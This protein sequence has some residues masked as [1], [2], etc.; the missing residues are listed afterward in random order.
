MTKL[1]A[2]LALGLWGNVALFSQ[3]TPYELKIETQAGVIAVSFSTE[4]GQARVYLPDDVAPGETFSGTVEAT[5]DF[6]LEFAGQTAKA[7]ADSFQWTVPQV[8]NGEFVPLILRSVRG[9][10]L[11]RASIRVTAQTT[12]PPT[13]FHVPRFVQAGSFFPIP[14]SFDGNLKSTS[15]VIDGHAT[16]VFAESPRKAIVR[17]PATVLGSVDYRLTAKGVETQGRIRSLAIE[18]T[19]PISNQREGAPPAFDLTVKGLAGLEDDVPLRI[20]GN[21]FYLRPDAVPPEGVFRA[22]RAFDGVPPGATSIPVSLIIPQTPKEE[23]GVILRT[24][25]RDPKRNLAEQH[26]EAL[27]RLDFDSIPPIAQF[28]TDFDLGSDAAY[29]MLT[30]D[31]T[32]ALTLLFD[33]MPA[34]GP[35]IERLGMTWFLDHYDFAHGSR[36]AEAAHA[37]AVRLLESGAKSS[38]VTTDLALY[39]VG[40]TGS[41]KD[42]PLL[43]RYYEYN[44]RVSGL[45]GTHDASEAA[46]TRLGSNKQLEDIRAELSPAL[47]ADATLPEGVKLVQALDKAGY[48]GRRE[49]VP[50][51]CLHIA[52]PIVLE[53]DI[54]TNPG[55]HA[56]AALSAIVD[57]TNP[58]AATAKRTL[59]EWMSYCRQ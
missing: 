43:T 48:S 33:S 47:R 44:S 31:E 17:A 41:E 12:P 34:S 53:I 16:R 15:L 2:I 11:A 46:L 24:P 45:K 50:E 14:G 7:S 26:A 42:L 55:Q 29:A 21:Y 49:L 37:A 58:R 18:L 56:L 22:T 40:L 27:R 30:L 5:R 28:L 1:A 39:L 9:Q 20:A 52:D 51:V 23:V 6:V 35:N 54:G 36:N 10:E 4:S 32:R 57:G 38:T 8:Q 3:V 59:A 19:G 25:Q 13:G